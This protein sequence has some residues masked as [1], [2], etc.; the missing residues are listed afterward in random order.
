MSV[1]RDPRSVEPKTIENILLHLGLDA[2]TVGVAQ[3]GSIKSDVISGLRAGVV[4]RSG[5]GGLSAEDE[6]TRSVLSTQSLTGATSLDST[7]VCSRCKNSEPEQ[8]EWNADNGDVVCRKCGTVAMDHA[9]F[10]GEAHRNFDDDEEDKSHAGRNVSEHY[11]DSY[12]LATVVMPT[13]GSEDKVKELKRTLREI[14][15]IEHLQ[16][17]AAGGVRFTRLWYKDNMKRKVVNFAC[18]ASFQTSC[19]SVSVSVSVCVLSPWL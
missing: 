6:V 4:T 16:G 15:T 8:F 1:P 3:L 10:E 11:S 17:E 14:E 12:N 2:T 13:D 9:L 19:T 18:A 7:L 5:A